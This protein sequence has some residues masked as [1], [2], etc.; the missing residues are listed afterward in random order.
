MLPNF[1]ARFLAG[2]IAQ[3]KAIKTTPP[4]RPRVF[5]VFLAL[6]IL[7]SHKVA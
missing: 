2:F 7:W 3:L 6:Q 1:V 4:D 5:I